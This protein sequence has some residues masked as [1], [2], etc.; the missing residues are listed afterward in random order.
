M[1]PT[2][3]DDDNCFQNNEVADHLTGESINGEVNDIDRCKE[4]IFELEDSDADED[5]LIA[6]LEKR[7]QQLYKH[8]LQDYS[9]CVLEEKDQSEQ[10]IND[11]EPDDCLLEEFEAKRIQQRQ[12]ELFNEYDFDAELLKIDNSLSITRCKE[13]L[14]K[15]FSSFSM[16]GKWQLLCRESPELLPLISKYK[17]ALSDLQKK[18][19]PIHEYCCLSSTTYDD[20][21]Q[22]VE[23]KVH[24]L[25]DFVVNVSCYLIF[26]AT[27]EENL[28]THPLMERIL[29]YQVLIKELETVESQL[30]LKI[31]QRW[32]EMTDVKSVESK[33]L[34]FHRH[35]SQTSSK[36]VGSSCAKMPMVGT[37]RNLKLVRRLKLSQLICDQDGESV[38][39]VEVQSTHITSPSIKKSRV[40]D[41]FNENIALAHYKML[42]CGQLSKEQVTHLGVNKNNSELLLKNDLDDIIEEKNSSYAGINDG[43]RSITHEIQKNRGLTPRRK[44]EHKNPRV[45]NRLKYRKAKIRR[46]GQIREVRHE[47]KPYTGEFSGIRAAVKRGTHLK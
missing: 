31:T 7:K 24:L 28:H 46:R 15:D 22:F 13:K 18:L 1:E 36:D 19:V 12:A 6:L 3:I 25:L 39:P 47:L 27:N 30:G 8:S 10:E 23:Q 14:V 2:E 29:L 45:K 9:S 34:S 16:S 20:V 17:A 37:C 41:S 42:T 4:E 35:L 33:S 5:E 44:K 26:K 32:I 38:K 21:F 11:S 43:R 40:G